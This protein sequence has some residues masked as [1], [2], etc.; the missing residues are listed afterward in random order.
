MGGKSRPALSDNRF[1]ASAKDLL[2]A[3]GGKSDSLLAE[4]G[5]VPEHVLFREDG[6][7]I[8]DFRKA[9]RRSGDRGRDGDRKDKERKPIVKITPLRIFS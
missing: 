4:K 5:T 1:R 8:R 9:W 7:P 2:E 6:R 3:Q